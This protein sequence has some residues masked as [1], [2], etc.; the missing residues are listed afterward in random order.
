[1]E[2]L[3]RIEREKRWKKIEESNYNETYKEIRTEE[4]PGYLKGRRKKKERNTIARYR[5]GNE[6]RGGRHWEKKEERNCRICKKR[7][8]DW[9]HILRECEDTREDVG[10]KELMD[11]DGKGYE[12]MK[13][14]EKKKRGE[15]EDGGG[16]REKDGEG[17][18][19]KL[20]RSERQSGES[21][22]GGRRKRLSE[23]I[24]L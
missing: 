17:G 5:C 24:E 10:I 13:K 23:N 14:I 16:N 19:N 1:M 22:E 6:I 18:G 3:E 15:K 11:G 12:I 7:E 4:R 20:K 2:R 9:T 8:E 21:G